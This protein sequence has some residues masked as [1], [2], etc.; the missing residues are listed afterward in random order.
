[1]GALA[2]LSLVTCGCARRDANGPVEIVYW[3]GWSGH[4]LTVLEKL[5]AEFNRTHHHIRVRMLTQF[6]TAGSYQK[7][8]IAFAG[9]ATPDV[10]STVWDKELAAY[11]LR[12]VLTPL[13]D[14]LR[15]SGRDLEQEY[16]PGVARM[17]RIGGRVWGLTITTNSNLIVYNKRIFREVGLDPE[18]PPANIKEFERAVELCTKYDAQ[19]RFL[20][21]GFRPNDLRLWAYVFGG[22]WYDER[23]GRVTANNPRN[24]AALKWLSS[25][26]KYDLKKMAAFRSGFGSQESANGPFYVGQMAMWATGEW[27]GEFIRRYAP[28]LEWGW[29]AYPAPA[30]GRVKTT[31]ARGSI[32]VIP[33]A[34]KRKKEAWEFLNWMTSVPA[35]SEF[36]WSI[37]NVP[38]LKA[39]G[40]DRRFQ[41]DPFFRLAVSLSNGQNSFGP[42]PTPIWPTYDREL[43]RV[44]EAALLG[45]K[46]PQRLLDDLQVRMERE[47]QRTMAELGLR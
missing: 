15:A 38:P 20:R 45:G 11:A 19:G 4:E 39:A 25:F 33:A 43:D 21:F 31:S 24:V 17:L 18:R 2:G 47:E 32:F 26:R 36:C 42:P 10:M 7:V 34:C 5:T 29:F 9:G 37:K 13:D 22:A 6:N 46:D 41:S 3:T 1:M 23:A 28:K 35:V 27:S 14:L 8:R 40:R 30:D 16:T 44:E 12:G